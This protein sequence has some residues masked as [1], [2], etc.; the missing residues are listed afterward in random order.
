[1]KN[2]ITLTFPDNSTRVYTSGTTLLE[3][4]ESIGT[5]LAK[6]AVAAKINGKLTDLT[7]SINTDADINIVTGDTS[8]GHEV[9]LHS[10]AHLMA[11]AVKELFP[12]ARVTIGPAIENRFYYDFDVENPFTDEDLVTIEEKMRELAQNNYPVK[13]KVFSKDDAIDLFE[14]MDETY[15][16]EIIQEI[17]PEETLSAYQQ[18]S[19]ID[20]CR[21][22]HVP[23]TGR[24]KYFKILNSSGAYWR[25]DENNKMLQRIYGTVF[26]TKKELKEYLQMLEEAKKRDHRKLG[27]ELGLF[28]FD[29]E[30][31]PGLPLWLP[32][33]TIIIE[34]LEKLAK[35]TERKAGYQ[36]VR[37]PHLTKGS[38]YEK[39][40]HLKHYKE[41]MYPA[42]DVDGIDYYVKPMNCPHHHK[43]YASAPRSYRDLPLRL[44]EYG[45][46]YRY[47]KSG[48]LFGLM[49]VR[50]MQMNDAHIYCTKE[51]FKEEFLSVFQMYLTYFKIFGIDKYEM[52]LCL[53]SS[54][55]LGKKYV[56]EP[57]L[58]IQTEQ[59]VRKALDEGGI[60]YTEKSGE[61]AFYGPKIDVQ[62]WSTIGRK[63]TLATN[64]V[65]FAIPS[66]FG[67][68]YTNERGEEATPLCI[69]RAPLGTHER[70]IGFLIEHYNADFPLWLAPVQVAILTVSEKVENYAKSVQSNLQNVDVRVDLDDRPDK[71]G[72]KIRR[73]ELSKINIMLIIGEQEAKENT[74]SVRRRFEGD[75]GS[76]NVDN[77]TS[78]LVE[79][80]NQ[81]RNTYRKEG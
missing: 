6:D 71:I 51:Q 68:N 43:I 74:V 2:Q 17:P 40:G 5:R 23:S 18:D 55:G 32:K 4:A 35:E 59:D 12:N 24:I 45:T 21:G 42:M 19:F 56:N 69:H 11:Q 65:D 57:E 47:E 36:R 78:K 9:L 52:E 26:N 50:S 60:N 29:D 72:A 63:F 61:A 10:T 48:E 33:G 66:L 38:L 46:C 28:A 64:Q 49:R 70:F 62:V 81:R 16:V 22:P 80:I 3:V 7:E 67:L 58:W 20:L 75:I 25:G 34:E 8:E 14:S 44:A 37:T 31:G 15:K 1:M 41:S 30:I 54:E 79:E 39:S 13:R 77:L 53:H 27:K 73:A 76:M